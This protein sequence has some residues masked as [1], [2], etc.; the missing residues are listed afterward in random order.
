MKAFQYVGN[1]WISFLYD[2][3]HVD[4]SV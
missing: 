4:T 1:N 2:V 3:K